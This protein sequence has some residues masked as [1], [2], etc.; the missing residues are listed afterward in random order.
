MELEKLS[1]VFMFICII[2]LFVENKNIRNDMNQ[3]LEHMTSA[4][5]S[6]TPSTTPPSNSNLDT[7]RDL[8]RQEYNHDIEAIRNLGS[9]SKSLLTGKN[10]H[11]TSPGSG[12]G[13][14]LIIPAN[15]QIQGNLKT[16]GWAVAVPI[17]TVIMWTGRTIPPP[18]NTTNYDYTGVGGYTLAEHEC[19]YPCIGNTTANV[20]GVA[21]PELRGRMV[22]GQGVHDGSASE[23]GGDHD[24]QP[25]LGRI[26]G[27]VPV[28]H[29]THHVNHDN[30]RH[31]HQINLH[32]DGHSGSSVTGSDRGT[33]SHNFTQHENAHHNHILNGPSGTH[34]NARTDNFNKHTVPH[35]TILQFWIRVR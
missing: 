2:A 16:N 29:H 13:G 30:A 17:G 12:N 28:G 3:N 5:S 9:I 32:T 20:L 22:M 33:N 25:L 26:G 8:I 11:N 35:S 21:I 27:M 1:L 15:V 23:V 10:Y 4:G 31:R 34:S 6:G 14:D 18:P 19:W 7:I 24:M